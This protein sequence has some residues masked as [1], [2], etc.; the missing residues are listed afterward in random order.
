[1]NELTKL[2][3]KLENVRHHECEDGWY[4]CPL[5]EEGCYDERQKECDCVAGCI[6][7]IA[8]ELR[9]VIATQEELCVERVL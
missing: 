8:A 6:H 2:C 3:E 7:Q 4:S 1:M 5:S 9:A